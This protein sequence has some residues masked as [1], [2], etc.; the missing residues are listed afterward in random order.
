[1]QPIVTAAR[2]LLRAL[3]RI[4]SVAAGIA[5]LVV[6][7]TI[8]L[9]ATGRYTLGL[10][11]LGGEE[12]ARLLTV[13]ITFVAAYTMLREDGHVSIDLV[14][15]VVPPVVQRVFR[16]LIAV[17]GTVTMAYLAYRAYQ[18]SAFSLGTGQMGT[19]LPVPRGLFF[20][21]VCLGAVLM[22]L[23]FVEKLVRAITDTLPPLPA[24]ADTG[25]EGTP[26]TPAAP[27][28]ETV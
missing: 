27:R 3:D 21:P 19:T 23:A 17:I 24:L 15:R 9:N 1:M 12:L 4:V 16:G 7:F 28:E 13:W 14:L 26:L 20:V 6:T 25:A 11:F 2:V 22:T 8:F 10:S 18:L 5:L